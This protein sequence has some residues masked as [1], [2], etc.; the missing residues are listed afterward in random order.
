[1]HVRASVVAVILSILAA[2]CGSSS[3]TATAPAT[4][5]RC[6]VTL[7]VTDLSVP[8]SGGTG[9]IGVSAA[10]ECAWTASSS[11]SWVTVTGPASGQGDGA[12][13]YSVGP[14]SDATTR[15][16]VIE[17][18]DQRANLTQA[19][20]DC[21]MSL[22]DTSETFSNA[23][24][25]GT[26][27]VRASSATCSWTA[28]SDANWIT[29]RSGASGSGNGTVAFD[30]A[31]GTGTPRTGTI[32]VAGLRFAITQAEGCTFGVSPGSYAPGAA[33][34]ST[35]LAVTTGSACPWTAI[36]NVP[37]ITVPQ[38]AS[39]T[40]PG[41]VRLVVEATSGPSRT[42]TVLVAGQS[43]T[44]S[45]GAGCSISVGPLSQPFSSAGGSGSARIEADGGCPW[46]AGS[47]AAWI[48]LTG[49]TS[50]NGSGT[51]AFT[52][53][54]LTGAA[55]TGTISVA[56][57]DITITQGSGCAF[58]VTPTST[59]VAATG[60]N[61]SIS[62]TTGADCAWS[63]SSNASWLSI[64]AGAS[65]TGNGT[66]QFSAAATAGGPR[67]AMLT[68]AGQ[69]VTV[70]QTSGCTSA[71]D[72]TSANVPAQG[73]TG[74]ISV[75]SAD[76]CTWTASS[77]APW[78]SITSGASGTGK[79]TVQFSAAAGG[80]RTGTL[81]VG[82][83][84][85]TVNQAGNCAF[86][87][88]R[89]ST[90]VP[91]QGGTG[92]VT[93][94][95]GAGCAWSASSNAP[96][97]SITAGASGTGNGTVQ[98]SAAA[99]EPRTGTLTIGGQTFTVTQE[100]SC[101][102]AID[103]KEATVP[104]QGGTGSVTVTSAGGCAWSASS[105]APW[106][107]ITSGATGTGNGTVRFSA[108][109]G[110]PRTGTLTIA[111]QTFT[112]TQAA[113]CTF[114]IDP[115]SAN[116]PA[117]GGTGSVT[118]A[119]G[120]GCAWTAT[121]NAPW[122]SIT[123]GASGTGNGTVQFSAAAGGPRTG[124]LTIAGQTFTVTQAANCNFGFGPSGLTIPAAGGS[125]NVSVSAGAGCAW[126]A[127]SNASWL[128]I[129]SGN[130]GNGS[131]T[132]TIVAAA[133]PSVARSATLTIGGQ[134]YTVNQASGCS[135]AVSPTKTSTPV[136]AG[137]GNV[138]VAVAA[139]AGC[140][141]TAS[142]G[143]D[144]ITVTSGSSGNGNGAATI[145]AAPNAG[146]PR[147]GTVTVAGTTV[148]I[149]QAGTSCTYSIGPTSRG[150]S[151]NGGSHMITVTA[152]AGCAWTATSNVPWITITSGASG[153]GNGT[154]EYTFAPNNTNVARSGTIT[155]AGLTYT[156]DQSK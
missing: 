77:N 94:T 55:R 132:V 73:G 31:P 138:T 137:G 120:A 155:I 84:T 37:W 122:L 47:N 151:S 144:W 93:V 10:R 110:G 53:A 65:G 106:L 100:G 66:V 41:T 7:A 124:T 109:A 23:G 96:W 19:A 11:V 52:V 8:A 14:N 43:V 121:S 35:T 95:S 1:M 25:S 118:V 147:S 16:G 141:W 82:G 140:T 129:S 76:G 72:P 27:P 134:S 97:L 146:A 12:I 63:A 89:T 80:P 2:G 83:Q 131:G 74:S 92:S 112:V 13:E 24:G 15:R 51:I 38:G 50:G 26:I 17:L 32:L 152:G 105:N 108:A 127:S 71:I 69:A 29:I 70:S 102:F 156:Q 78:L 28:A 143:V 3:T 99:G 98:F 59:S 6:G 111:G 125:A 114:A 87:I 79:G 49:P 39:G 145:A 20:A 75:T 149:E 133:N 61:G 44:I 117:Q 88:D 46:S 136:G 40:G 22:G 34:G 62:V 64:S 4:V 101:S 107:S 103:Q 9:R 130:N 85:F 21:T 123:G 67:S 60:G 113:N 18:N 154:V 45:Q 33:G 142:S 54:P 5:P 119:G 148:T 126:T 56:G 48:T 57:T 91:A 128:T 36:S 90:T 150:G 42:G 58:S 135:F 139:A 104:A 68:I 115:T 81:T 30:V 116:V 86:T 153:T